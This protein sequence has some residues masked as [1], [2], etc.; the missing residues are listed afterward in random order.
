MVFFRSVIQ[1][2]K[3][4]DTVVAV[5]SEDLGDFG[6]VFFADIA[7]NLVGGVHNILKKREKYVIIVLIEAGTVKGGL[8]WSFG[9]TGGFLVVLDE[10]FPGNE[11][12]GTSRLF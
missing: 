7:L 5:V 11:K 12:K 9:F 4:A 2:G 10:E 1:V 3:T 8:G 6:D